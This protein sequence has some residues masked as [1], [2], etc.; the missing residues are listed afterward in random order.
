MGGRKLSETA[1]SAAGMSRLDGLTTWDAD[2]RG[3]RVVVTG[4]GLSGFSAAD[5]LIEL[6][7]RVV[8]VDAR[9]TEENRAKADTLRI[10][11][12][13]DVLLGAEHA[14]ALPAVE[15]EPAELVVTS[16]GFSP[17]HPLMRMAADGGIPVWGDVELAWRVR[18]REGRKTA[19]WLTITGTNGKTTTVS[20]TESML[21]AAGLR[22][23]AAGNVGTPILDAIRDP[24]GYDVLA[25]ELSSFQLHWSSSLSPLASVCLNIAEDHV[26]WHGSYEAYRADKAKIYENTRVA[27]I[28]NAE[29]AETEHMVEEADVVEGCRAV[30]FTTGMPAVSM[31][32]MVE[33]LLV[34]RA[35]IEQRKDSAA[36]LA[37]MADLGEHAPRHMVA[38]ALA[39]AALVRAYGVEPVAVRDG[40][41]AYAP[42]DHRI[43]AVAR[44]NDIFWINDSKATNPHAA[45]ASLSA[46]SSVVW[47]A[48]GLSKGVHYEDL[49]RDHAS[50][51]R[52]VVLIGKDSSD[53]RTAL[54]RHAP[55]VRVIDAVP[56]HTGGKH[57]AAAEVSG[58]DVMA[59]AVAAAAAEARPGDTVLMAPAAASMD[60]F[61]SYAHRG[62]AFI[63]AVRGYVEGQAQTPKEP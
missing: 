38:N 4:I 7:A 48:G 29:Q 19:E 2:W 57:A 52:S 22:A 28:Y 14:E 30:G 44:L 20:M 21:R 1:G 54:A 43:Q 25:V 8:V 31:V 62:D 42:G 26:D 15:G 24:Q 27:C 11:G 36:E 40:L 5:T 46:F 10:V 33:N 23:I 37:S 18:I 34:D 12:A 35:F 61:A 49:V 47:I 55:G 32:G 39:A 59:L 3:L 6:G 60:Q 53:L 63:E 17:S 9:D 56:P 51:I 58:E 45:S 41:R 16:P 13:A 50:R